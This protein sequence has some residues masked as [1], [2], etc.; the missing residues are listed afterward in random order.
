MA[1]LIFKWVAFAL[2]IMF[3]SWVIP[4][5]SVENFFTAMIAT[6][7]IVLINAIIKPVLMLLALP[8]NIATLG[9][10]SLVINAF[11][12]M[13]AAYLVQGIEINGFISAF[14][15]AII[16]SVFSAVITRL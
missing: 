9:I 11:L 16:I 5:I 13:F 8:I 7:V 3:V 14:L 15:G 2:V 12:L 6:V 1:K 10:F 4:G